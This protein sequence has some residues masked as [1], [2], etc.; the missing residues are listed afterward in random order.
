MKTRIISGIALTSAD[1][2]Q[3]VFTYEY[4]GQTIDINGELFYNKR[5]KRFE[6]WHDDDTLVV[7]NYEF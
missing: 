4:E 3:G 5:E 7:W 6:H 1:V 2:H